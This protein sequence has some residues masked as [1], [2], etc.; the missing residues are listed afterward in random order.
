MNAASIGS[1]MILIIS[2]CYCSLQ[3]NARGTVFF[4]VAPLIALLGSAKRS[5]L[6]QQMVVKSTFKLVAIHILRGF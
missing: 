4:A 2:L 1:K 6:H 3:L 5:S